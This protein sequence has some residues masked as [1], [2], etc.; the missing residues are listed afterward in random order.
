MAEPDENPVVKDAQPEKKGVKLVPYIGIIVAIALGLAGTLLSVANGKSGR[1]ADL[2]RQVKGAQ[3]K[4]AALDLE[5]TFLKSA[6]DGRKAAYLDPSS[7]GGYT[8]MDSSAGSFVV[9]LE[10]VQPYLDGYKVTLNIG[11]LT[12]ATY[13]GFTLKA[14][15]GRDLFNFAQSEK[16]DSSR[17]KNFSFTQ[18]LQPGAWNKVQIVI[19]STKP[20]DFKFL[21]LSIDT[22]VISLSSRRVAP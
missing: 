16:K 19:P 13:Q 17:Q 2:E 9:S 7:P 11:N 3:E 18:S 10:D 5:V 20:E 12:S 6:L 8:R 22:D 14:E 1:I 15:W 4:I 21:R